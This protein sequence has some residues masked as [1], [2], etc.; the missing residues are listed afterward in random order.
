MSSHGS[1]RHER[2]SSIHRPLVIRKGR[3]SDGAAVLQL[4][5][6]LADYEKLK[7]PTPAA[8]RRLLADAFGNHPRFDLFLAFSGSLAV[9]YA[10]ILETYSSFLALPTLYL[11]DLFVLP[12][13]RRLGVGRR[14]FERCIGEAKRRGCG[15]MDWVVLDWNIRARRFYRTLRAKQLRHWLLYRLDL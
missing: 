6:A 4:I 2:Q 13:Y 12:A 3:K 7:R 10:M 9:G 1:R 15:R 8:R 14:L 11:E 5:D